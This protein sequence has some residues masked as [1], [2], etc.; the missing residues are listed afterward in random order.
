MVMA[1]FRKRSVNR[2]NFL[3]AAVTGAATLAVPAVPAEALSLGAA[4]PAPRVMPMFPP[5][6]EA[7]PSVDLDVLT[8]DRSGSD[9]MVDVIKSL[10]FEYVCAVAGSSFRGLHESVIN[11]GANRNPEFL[12]CCHEESAVAMGHGYAKIEGKPLCVFAHG[13]VGLQHASMAIYNAYCDRVPVYLIVANNLDATMRDS[14]YGEWPHSVQDAALM[15]RDYTKWDD[16]PISLQHFAESAVRAYKIAMTPPG[17]PV[18]LV[19]DSELQENPIREGAKLEIPKLTLPAPPQGD[20]GAVAEAARLLVEA[21][22]PVIVVDRTARTQAGMD[23][24]VEL[25]E[26]LQAP[27]I[28]KLARMNFPTHHPLNQTAR[29]RALI[30]DADVI[31]G[32]EVADFWSTVNAFHDQVHRTSHPITKTG[33]KLIS[34][35]VGDIYTKANY[36]DFFRYTGVDLAIAADAEATVPSLIEAIKRQMNP[37]RKRTFQDRGSELVLAHQ[38]ALE[39]ARTEATYGWDA[40]PVSTA[41]L[42]SELWAQIKDEDWSMVSV[43]KHFSFWPLRLWPFDK[44]YQYIGGQ[45]GGG[46]GY[47]APATVGAALANRKHGR[48]SVSIQDDGDLLFTP[49]VLWTAAHHRIPLLSVMHNN[50][51]YHEELMHVQRMACRHNRGIDRAKIGTTFEDPNIDF[52]KLAQSMGVYA[53]GPISDPIEVGPALARAVAVVKRGEPALVDVVGQPR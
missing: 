47:N 24:L 43:M 48:L 13:T 49:T 45:G 51:A 2:R 21:Q 1:K 28:D 25:A 11:Y 18:L 30:S 31:L 29:S 23:S 26:L 6:T 34:I 33:A 14:N 4:S 46:I 32:L 17:G 10:G 40:S 22:S 19:A 7:D 12:T 20:S 38:K 35:T 44:H 52:A 39:E 27:V 53:E 8:L 3:K 16:L 37:D 9:F 50:R 5:A 42:C 41:R 15:V 36:Q